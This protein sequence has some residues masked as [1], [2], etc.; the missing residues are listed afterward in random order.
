MHKP[1]TYIIM[2]KKVAIQESKMGLEAPLVVS[3]VFDNCLYSGF[4]GMLDSER[5]KT[6]TTLILDSVDTHD[7]EYM[8]IDLSNVDLIDSAIAA[9]LI[10]IG[11]SL[12]ISGVIVVFCGIKSSV[13]QTMIVLGVEFTAFKIAK[14]LNKALQ[15]IYNLSGYEL[16][17]K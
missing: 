14:D 10:K 13:A 11:N 15:I 2:E 1:S 7:C 5:I 17:K 16:V 4:F 12:K 6:I 3:K 8:I 9:H